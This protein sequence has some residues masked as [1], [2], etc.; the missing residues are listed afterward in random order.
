[1]NVPFLKGDFTFVH[2]R[3]VWQWAEVCGMT[4]LALAMAHWANPEDPYFIRAPFA[5]P[6]IVPALLGLRYGT[7]AVVS[8]AI[9]FGGVWAMEPLSS[10]RAETGLFTRYFLGGLILSLVCGQF[11]SLWHARLSKAEQE[12]GYLMDRLE[13]LTRRHLVLRLSHSQLEQ[14]LVSK[15]ITL[16]DAL[17]RLR[18]MMRRNDPELRPDLARSLLQL[19]GQYFQLEVAGFYVMNKG[20]VL[21]EPF[22]YLGQE[23][24]F[25]LSD[26][27]AKNALQSGELCF[28]KP[29]T[30]SETMTGRYLIV[31]PC[32]VSDGRIL[33]WLTISHLRFANFH[34]ETFRM[35]KVFL[36]YFA[37][38]LQ[39][40][41]LA[42]PILN[43]YPHC[44][45]PFAQ[46][47]P[48][49]I[50]LQQQMGIHSHLVVF[51]CAPHQHQLDIVQD[52][53]KVTR[54]VD[55]PWQ[56]AQDDLRLVAVLLPFTDAK[57]V[58]GYLA[59]IQGLLKERY[60]LG[61]SEAKVTPHLT[62]LDKDDALT[63]L[64]NLFGR[65]HG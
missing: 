39:S 60:Q 47:L 41:W 1:M 64:Q 28:L 6:W 42:Q 24:R 22:A 30:V 10:S 54:A 63:L 40:M 18:G 21:D 2:R 20:A 57:G 19:L 25:D 27:L 61:F 14:H 33:G 35:L 50:R 26:P 23:F 53:T 9:M 45:V 15:P 37:D 43:A 8:S 32:Q 12:N 65:C 17:K 55:L 11:G 44:P 48:K 58:E 13:Q 62:E 7:W 34:H 49:L 31:A 4:G 59:R 29:E 36:G 46:E 3:P 38:T 5:W 52:I 16:R 56:I 51:A